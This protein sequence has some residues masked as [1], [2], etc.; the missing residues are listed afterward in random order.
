MIGRTVI[1]V[2]LSALVAW[3]AL[4]LVLL[5]FRPRGSLRA[6]ACACGLGRAGLRER[7]I[8]R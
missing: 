8:K 2:V 3:G 6:L 5:I 1:T 4:V 7:V